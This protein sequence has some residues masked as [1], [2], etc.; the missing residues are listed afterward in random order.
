MQDFNRSQNLPEEAELQTSMEIETQSWLD[1]WQ[2]LNLARKGLPLFLVVIFWLGHISLAGFR[3][4]H[5][6]GGSIF[7][8]LYYG[9]PKTQAWFRFML[10]VIL[11]LALYDAQGYIAEAI[12]GEVRVKEPYLFDE[13][14]FGIDTEEGRL[15]PSDWL[16]KHTHPFL[17][18]ITGLSY[19]IFIPVFL[20]VGIYF[21]FFLGRKGTPRHSPEEVQLKVSAMMWGMFW[22]NLICCSTYYWY[23]AAPPWYVYMYGFRPPGPDL[24]GAAAGLINFDRMIGLNFMTTLW[25]NFNA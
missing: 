6:I 12:R 3:G 25:D 15:L 7:L 13:K 20:A 10:P 1:W 11:Y 18:F 2:N 8:A 22:L 21:R 4:D 14:F 23:P 16:Q 24:Y 9:G 17:D 5:F 19:L